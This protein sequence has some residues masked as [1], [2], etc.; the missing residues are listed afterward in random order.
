MVGD[1][2]VVNAWP[3]NSANQG[4]AFE[5][6]ELAEIKLGLIVVYGCAKKPTAGLE[7]TVG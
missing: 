7:N 5:Q 2:L 1:E 6:F 4:L 3:G